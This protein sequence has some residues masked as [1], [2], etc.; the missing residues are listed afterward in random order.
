MRF[1]HSLFWPK[2]DEQW[3]HNRVSGNPDLAWQ[4]F[5]YTAA[6]YGAVLSMLFTNPGDQPP[7]THFSFFDF[8]WISGSL[9]SPLAAFVAVWLLRHARGRSLYFAFWLRLSSGIGMTTSLVAYESQRLLYSTESH[10]FEDSIVVAA[11][12]FLF[13][14]TIRDVRLISM[15]ERL[16]L[17][18][19]VGGAGACG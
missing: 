6:F 5:L 17:K 8:L 10:P 18:L 1:L 19:R 3:V 12:L 16:A 13:T 9:I 11:I 2:L 4:P 14:L 7:G 15:T